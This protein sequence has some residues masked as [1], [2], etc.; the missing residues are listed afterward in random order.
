MSAPANLASA[1]VSPPAVALA[2]SL[3]PSSG[4]PTSFPKSKIKVLLL[5][6]ISP[7]AI[8]M[9]Q[10]EGYQVESFDKSLSE[11]VLLEKI[12]DVHAIGVRSK[13][14]LTAEVIKAAPK[15]LAIGCFCIGTDQTD[16]EA[17]SLNGTA[18]FNAPFA[19]TRSVAELV[20]GE[21]IML[22]RQVM[23][24][25]S[26]CHAKKWNKSA[27]GCVEVRGKT[28]AIVGYGHVGSQL[29]VLAEA[30]GMHVLFYDIVPKLPLGN[31]IAQDSLEAAIRAADFLSLHVPAEAG[32]NNLIGAQE[33]GWLKPGSYL[34]NASRGSVVDI[35]AAAAAL[36]S[37]HLAGAAFDVYPEE[38]AAVGDPFVTPLQGC[39]NTILTPHV[40][41]STEEA[42]VAIGREVAQKMIGYINA[43][44]TLGSVNLPELSLPKAKQSH[45]ILN[46]H[47][48]QPGVLKEVNHQLSDFNINAQ[49][50]M[51]KGPIGYMI[52]DVDKAVSKDV[53]ERMS[54]IQGHIKTRILY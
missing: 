53:K 1:S 11:S 19:N 46:I 22:A 28:L 52:I 44:L 38:P 25:S 2:V 42:Q 37:G 33:I 41:G 6:R 34:I 36:R 49:M 8:K 17:A 30:L 50:L 26:E 12:K 7:A 10:D 20:L 31:A 9:M 32:T 18:V 15:L 43:G 3:S 48:N 47:R 29:S 24:R 13:T 45:R 14:M 23:D 51:T 39:R 5:E 4:G 21:M 16:L 54:H 35:D 40:G 27:A